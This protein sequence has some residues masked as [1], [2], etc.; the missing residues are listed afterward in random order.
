MIFSLGIIFPL[1]R[2][3]QCVYFL[4]KYNVLSILS[5]VKSGVSFFNVF[6]SC[7]SPTYKKC[8]FA[9]YYRNPLTS[10]YPFTLYFMKC[11][12]QAADVECFIHSLRSQK[13]VRGE[14]KAAVT[15]KCSC[16]KMLL[17]PFMHKVVKWPNI[18]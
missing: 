15:R 3:L 5:S 14:A 16:K 2:L 4:P 11:F 1:V 6:T 17:N 9:S 18:L 8:T 13:L 10:F 12:I 7:F